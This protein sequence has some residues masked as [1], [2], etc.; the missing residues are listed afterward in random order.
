MNE[1]AQEKPVKASKLI[2]ALEGANI[3]AKIVD[4]GDLAPEFCGVS[5][6][7]YDHLCS[8]TGY[9]KFM[10][11][12]PNRPWAVSRE[13]LSYYEAKVLGVVFSKSV[14]GAKDEQVELLGQVIE[15]DEGLGVQDVI[16]AAEKA[17]SF[18]GYNPDDYKFKPESVSDEDL[19]SAID[20][21]L[22]DDDDVVF[23][24]DEASNEV[25]QFYDYE[26]PPDG[27]KKISREKAIKH[28]VKN[29]NAISFKL[30]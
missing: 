21:E 5:V 14:R 23:F 15:Y 10:E 26:I 11:D 4:E 8:V 9:Y 29:R 19:H 24:V 1:E 30:A 3:V 20:D 7:V 13:N 27:C 25:Y 2:K 12:G 16:E 6:D 22:I 28:F 18:P 17:I